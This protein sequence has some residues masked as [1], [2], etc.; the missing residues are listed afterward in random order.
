[1]YII[2]SEIVNII[3]SISREIEKQGLIHALKYIILAENDFNL[4]ISFPLHIAN[5]IP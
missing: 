4:R 2:N 5:I 1:M 3:D